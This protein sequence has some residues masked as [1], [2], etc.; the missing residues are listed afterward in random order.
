MKPVFQKCLDNNLGTCFFAAFSLMELNG[1]QD[2]LASIPTVISVVFT[3][4]FRESRI[5]PWARE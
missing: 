2:E 4:V 3:T 1:S 5:G